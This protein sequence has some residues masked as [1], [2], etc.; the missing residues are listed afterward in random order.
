MPDFMIEH[1]VL[2]FAAVA[3][4]AFCFKHR[5]PRNADMTAVSEA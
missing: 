1:A 4:A 3:L 2:I 5:D